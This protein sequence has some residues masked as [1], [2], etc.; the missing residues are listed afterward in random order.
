MKKPYILTSNLNNDNQIVYS[1]D[2]VNIDDLMKMDESDI[3]N[4]KNDVRS[5]YVCCSG[6]GKYI[7]KSQQEQHKNRGVEKCF[8]CYY[9]GTNPTQHYNNGDPTKKFKEIEDGIYLEINKFSTQLYCRNTSGDL[10]DKLIKNICD[11]NRCMMHCA[12]A[13]FVERKASWWATHP[14][15]F[16][17]IITEGVMLNNPNW[18]CQKTGESSSLGAMYS[19]KDKGHS[20][21]VYFDKNGVLRKIQYFARF[22][23]YTLRYSVKYDVMTTLAGRVFVPLSDTKIEMPDYIMAEIKKLYEVHT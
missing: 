11:T 6:C 4:I 23:E 7:H 22:S 8:S 5:E 19:F 13:D 17:I 9:L 21:Y 12:T 2:T 16:D 15:A 14:G 1:W 20:L 18:V 3:I 10:R